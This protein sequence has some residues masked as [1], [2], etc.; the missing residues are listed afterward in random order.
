MTGT[1]GAASRQR[2]AYTFVARSGRAPATPPG[3]YASSLRGS[4]LAV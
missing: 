1:P 3:V 4:R 2:C